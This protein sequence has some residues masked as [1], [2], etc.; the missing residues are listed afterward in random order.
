MTEAATLGK[1]AKNHYNTFKTGVCPTCG[2]KIDQA[3]IDNYKNIMTQ[4]A[5]IYREN[6]AI[7]NIDEINEKY[8]EVTGTQNRIEKKA[9]GFRCRTHPV[10]AQ[11]MGL[12]KESLRRGITILLCEKSNNSRCLRAKSGQRHILNIANISGTSG[13]TNTLDLSCFNHLPQNRFNGCRTD[14]RVNCTN[15]SF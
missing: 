5:N 12:R 2:Q 8:K 13:I 1:Q 14:I 3:N 7:K 11:F 6:E 4:Y 10:A 9:F 15:F